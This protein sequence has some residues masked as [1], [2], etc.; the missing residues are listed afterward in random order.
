MPSIEGDTWLPEENVTSILHDPCGPVLG[1]SKSPYDSLC[2]SQSGSRCDSPSTSLS[3]I[4]R[5]QE[6][7]FQVRRGLQPCKWPPRRNSNKPDRLVDAPGTP[8][9]SRSVSP[10]EYHY[11]LHASLGPYEGIIWDDEPARQDDP[12]IDCWGCV[13][14]EAK[15]AAVNET[16]RLLEAEIVSLR[17][18]IVTNLFTGSDDDL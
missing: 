17:K 11:A 4:S 16:N 7:E 2:D 3:P 14:L 9:G 8:K 1:H 13:E 15:F 18:K 6:Y 12:E 5:Q 10:G